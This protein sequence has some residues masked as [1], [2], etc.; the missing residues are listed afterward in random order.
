MARKAPRGLVKRGQVWHIDKRICGTRICES[1]GTARLEEAEQL[2]ARRIEQLRKSRLFGVR[3]DHT[4]QEAATKFLLENRQK[5]TLKRDAENIVK[6]MPYIGH[7]PIR[8]ITRETLQPIIDHDLGQGL[9]VGTANHRLKVVRRILRLAA[10]EWRD[11]EGMTWL[12]GPPKITL[13]PDK[14]KRPAYPITWSEQGSL[15]E[16]LAPHL[17]AMSLFATNTCC[18]DAEICKLAWSWLVPIP[19]LDTYVFKVPKEVAK[20]GVSRFVILNRVALEIVESRRGEHKEFVFT[21]KGSPTKRM[22]NSGWRRARAKVGL[23]MV[24]VHDLRHTAAA[25]LRAAGVS[26]ED[27]ATLLG[28]T[29]GSMTTHYSA[30]YVTQLIDAVNRICEPDADGL[31]PVILR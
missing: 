7:L 13:L 27:R 30:A 1:T 15:F 9:A 14:N 12:Q 3:Q 26:H 20:N 2:L 16:E 5:R 19:A 11:D 10:Y 24:R 8:V 18:R 6:T 21:Y 28:H 22:N 17:K 4:F 29:N 25:R 31:D 23:P